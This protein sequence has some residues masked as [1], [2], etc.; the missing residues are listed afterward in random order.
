[1]I[2][3][4]FFIVMIISSTCNFFHAEETI[5]ITTKHNTDAS[6]KQFLK[7]VDGIKKIEKVKSSQIVDNELKTIDS[8]FI[9]TNAGTLF[10]VRKD[11]KIAFKMDN[12]SHFTFKNRTLKKIADALPIENKTILPSDYMLATDNKNHLLVPHITINNNDYTKNLIKTGKICNTPVHFLG[13]LD[14]E[15]NTFAIIGS[16]WPNIHLVHLPTNRETEVGSTFYQTTSDNPAD[17]AHITF[18]ENAYLLAVSNQQG[19]D[20]CI[21][22]GQIEKEASKLREVKTDYC[23]VIIKK[24]TFHK[25][26]T[27]ADLLKVEKIREHA[28]KGYQ[29]DE[30]QDDEEDE[31]DEPHPFR[32]EDFEH[33]HKTDIKRNYANGFETTQQELCRFHNIPVDG[34]HVPFLI[35]YKDD[36]HW[37]ILAYTKK[38]CQLITRANSKESQH[39]MITFAKKINFEDIF[40]IESN[41]K[42]TDFYSKKG[43]SY[44]TKKQTTA[45]F[46]DDGGNKTSIIAASGVS[47]D[48]ENV[49]IIENTYEKHRFLSSL[50]NKIHGPTKSNLKIIKR[51]D[52]DNKQKEEVKHPEKS[53]KLDFPENI[54][55]ITQKE[56]KTVE[57][58]TVDDFTKILAKEVNIN[59]VDQL[60]TATDQ[61]LTLPEKIDQPANEFQP[62]V[63]PK[64]LFKL[65]EK[66][67]IKTLLENNKNSEAIQN[68]IA[69]FAQTAILFAPT[70]LKELAASFLAL[71]K[72]YGI[73]IEKK[74]YKKFVN[75]VD[76][77]KALVKKR[78]WYFKKLDYKNIY[79]LD[80]Q[81]TNLKKI[82]HEDKTQ[83]KTTELF[84]HNNIEHELTPDE[85]KLVSLIG[86]FSQTHFLNEG[87]YCTKNTEQNQPNHILQGWVAL[88]TGA[89]FNMQN[90]CE[91]QDIIITPEQNTEE[92]G[93]GQKADQ[94]N[95]NT[96]M[97]KLWEQFY[98][99]SFE[100][101]QRVEIKR[102]IDKKQK[103]YVKL[104]L[105]EQKVWYFDQVLYK[106][107]MKMVL[108]PFLQL[109]ETV[110]KQQNKKVILYITNLNENKAWY[111]KFLYEKKDDYTVESTNELL[112]TLCFD[113]QK[114]IYRDYLQ[115]HQNTSIKKIYFAKGTCKKNGDQLSTK[116]EKL[117]TINNATIY[118]TNVPP[119]AKIFDEPNTIAIS[120]VPSEGFIQVGNDFWMDVENE[121]S[122][123]AQRAAHSFITTYQNPYINQQLLENM[124]FVD[125]EE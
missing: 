1:M 120:N 82:Y 50:F 45:Q 4:H 108:K 9:L 28:N 6:Q 66:N 21:I 18:L 31:L 115:T 122:M 91:W 94:E 99:D 15:H 33:K 92:N 103:R 19:N 100:L 107:R 42:Q 123:S 11:S 111:P 20:P 112:F 16:T 114:A 41:E 64:L 69:S 25:A 96:K 84:D 36:K 52:V 72:D 39:A 106:K 26:K 110:A 121:L 7:E 47:I 8:F 54:P 10:E 83:I 118:K 85:T 95:V 46:A 116:T 62:A 78:Y 14:F 73:N 61:L 76:F 48:D 104:F 70:K 88:Q 53:V 17:Y 44:L 56:V 63:D 32:D 102:T 97:R 59:L 81:K 23:M 65:D 109:V 105:N 30:L 74:Y 90:L 22:Y 98:N 119:A 77:L 79:T 58:K 40:A 12:L 124:V 71:K 24:M 113:L 125:T 86:S 75:E 27:A 93:Y 38:G 37:A 89:Y 29:E 35:D 101:Y 57:V 68:D 87:N 13:S 60:V 55:A 51:A 34:S 67:Q 2:K 49:Y 117:E 3:K 5:S 80:A 43:R